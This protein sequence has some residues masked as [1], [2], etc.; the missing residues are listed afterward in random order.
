M[1][2]AWLRPLIFPFV[3]LSA[4]GLILSVFVHLMALTGQDPGWGGAVWG[5][6]I[7]IFAVWIPTVL[8]SQ[9]QM[10]H[11]KRSDFWKI[12]MQGSPAWMRY[13]TMGLFAYAIVNFIIFIAST[14]G[15]PESTGSE[16]TPAALRG[17]SGH[18]MIF[19]SAA[20]SILYSAHRLGDRIDPKCPNG[21]PL[22][23]LAKF[24]DQ[25]GAAAPEEK[26]L[27]G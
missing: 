26:L 17:F 13:M 7:G 6:H 15:K 16:I 20:L 10:R 9:R 23:P 24:C 8:I 5:L 14:A 4:A 2:T 19:Y 18:W 11:A 25:C 27:K 21:H 12:A 1:K 3:I 22:S